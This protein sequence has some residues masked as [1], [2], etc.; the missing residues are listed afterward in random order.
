MNLNRQDPELILK[1]LF[2]EIN[3]FNIFIETWKNTVDFLR[4]ESDYVKKASR[5]NKLIYTFTRESCCVLF[6]LNNI[7]SI[8][9]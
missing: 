3:G 8:R 2:D 7:V 6:Y 9:F 1:K 4:D 5:F